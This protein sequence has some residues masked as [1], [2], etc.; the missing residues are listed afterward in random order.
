VTEA[1][2]ALDAAV[3]ALITSG[4]LDRATDTAIRGWGPEI[5]GWL[6]GALA[7]DTEATDAFAMFAEQVWSSFRRFDGRCSTRTWCYTL[8]RHCASRI[9]ETR[10]RGHNVPLSS[11]PVS[12]IPAAVRTITAAHR[13]TAVKD[14]LRSLRAGLDEE[15]Q[16]LLILR[17]D[18]ELGWR[19]I[20][21][22]LLGED[23]GSDDLER[24]AAT[25]RKRFER[26]KA[27]L[28]HHLGSPAKD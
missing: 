13:Q 7:D 27:T 14:E 9:R 8:A 25:L 2:T 19:E 16:M 28:R 4:A 5:Y 26:V 24:H 22:V 10:R 3:R 6:M 23:A 21:Q 20:A 1:Q 15:D 18:R 17:V 12:E 11:V